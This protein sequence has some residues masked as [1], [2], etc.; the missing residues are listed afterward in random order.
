MKKLIQRN[1]DDLMAYIV[2]A[3]SCEMAGRE[4]EARV[5]ATEILRVNPSFSLERLAK[6]APSQ[7]PSRGRTL[8]RSREQRI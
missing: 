3:S 6:N 5:A 4:E 8:H 7:G 2:L 1:P